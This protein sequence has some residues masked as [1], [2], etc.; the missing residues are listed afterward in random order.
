MLDRQAG[1]VLGTMGL[2]GGE[3]TGGGGELGGGAAALGQALYETTP[4]QGY[5]LAQLAVLVVVACG[6]QCEAVYGSGCDGGLWR[7]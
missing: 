7:G 5:W 1:G 4:T 6:Q 2:G 3:G